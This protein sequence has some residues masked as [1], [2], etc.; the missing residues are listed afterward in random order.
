M[1]GDL[2]KMVTRLYYRNSASGLSNLPAARQQNLPGTLISAVNPETTTFQMTRAMGNSI[3]V[4]SSTSAAITSAQEFYWN[5]WAS[6]PL[7]A[8]TINA[9]TWTHLMGVYQSSNNANFP[10]SGTGVIYLCVFLWRPGTGNVGTIIDGNS[11]ADAQE[12]NTNSVYKA[13]MCTFSG[14]SVTAQ[15][16]DVICQEWVTSTSQA[17][18]TAYAI[19]I[20]YNGSEILTAN[21]QTPVTA[22]NIAAYLETPQDLVFTD[23]VPAYLDMT[24]V[25]AADKALNFITKV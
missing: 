9:N 3:G 14:A 2:V 13:C 19:R 15:L 22:G 24:Q 1:V 11:N 25:A 16:N 20:S 5:R 8:Q 23:D 10:R 12:P 4:D 21:N 7:T 6:P 18:A 17:A